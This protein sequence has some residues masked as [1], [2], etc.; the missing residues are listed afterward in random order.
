[1]SVDDE[2]RGDRPPE[3]LSKLMDTL[4]Q[5]RPAPVETAP[6]T[7]SRED[8]G[9]KSRVLENGREGPEDVGDGRA[10]SEEG[11][12]TE[13]EKRL[14]RYIDDKFEELERRLVERLEECLVNRLTGRL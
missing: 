2:R 6:S 7:T 10:T 9:E 3:E 4:K 11:D 1:M 5:M 8:L 14:R 12:F 13:L